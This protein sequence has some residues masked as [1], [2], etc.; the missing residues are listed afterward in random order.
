MLSAYQSISFFI[1]A[2]TGIN[3]ITGTAK[4]Y[5]ISNQLIKFY[6]MLNK[7]RYRYRFYG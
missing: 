5:S 1:T 6:Y 4:Y 3:S 7:E 2:A